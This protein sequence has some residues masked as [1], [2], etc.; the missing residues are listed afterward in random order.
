MAQML[1]QV[2]K[3]VGTRLHCRRVGWPGKMPHDQFVLRM[4]CLQHRLQVAKV[5]RAIEE[6]VADQRDAIAMLQA[7]AKA[8]GRAALARTIPV[9]IRNSRR[10]RD[11]RRDEDGRGDEL[12]KDPPMRDGS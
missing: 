9:P 11:S 12:M 6:R 10:D 4:T 1:Q 8:G 7:R 3:I 2:G 5:S